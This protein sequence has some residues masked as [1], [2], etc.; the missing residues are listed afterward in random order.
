MKHTP[1]QE[2]QVVLARCWRALRAELKRDRSR[3]NDHNGLLHRLLSEVEI[4]IAHNAKAIAGDYGVSAY[5]LTPGTRMPQVSK[6]Q[7]SPY[8]GPANICRAVW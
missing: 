1:R 3:P 4:A 8:K 2:Q 7:V 6:Q 5:W